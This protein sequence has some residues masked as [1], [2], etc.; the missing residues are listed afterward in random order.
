MA[1]VKDNIHCLA[2]L[3]CLDLTDNRLEAL[4]EDIG[5]GFRSLEKLLLN[6]NALGKYRVLVEPGEWRMGLISRRAVADY[7]LRALEDDTT[8]GTAPVLVR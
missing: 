3:T 6:D 1:V 5:K 8:I 4:P 7:V 2:S